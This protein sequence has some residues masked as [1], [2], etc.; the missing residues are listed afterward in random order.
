ME[1]IQQIKTLWE[2]YEV[3]RSAFKN[4]ST[5]Q[6]KLCVNAVKNLKQFISTFDLIL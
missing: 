3:S 5:S 1:S 6:I 4:Q 2:T